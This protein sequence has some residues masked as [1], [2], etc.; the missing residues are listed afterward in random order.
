MLR[1]QRPDLARALAVTHKAIESRNTIPILS[2]VRLVA[3][4]GL[5]TVTATD[6]DIEIQT[7]VP[8]EGEFAACIDAKLLTGIAGKLAADDV[9]IEE[10]DNGQ[11]LLRA[12]KSRYR[13]ATL[14]VSD[15]PAVDPRNFSANF[16]AD[17]AA[18][19]APV[20]FAISDEETRFYLNGIYLHTVAGR[21]T[22]VATD[23]HQ[24]S[25]H[26][27]EATDIF[28]PVIIPR[29]TVSLIP[30][31]KVCVEISEVRIR[32]TA[33][34]TIITSNLINGTYPDYLR[35]VPTRNSK[36]V[37]VDAASLIAAVQR[38]SLLTARGAKLN[39][40]AG[41][42]ALMARG[43]DGEAEDAIECIYDGEPTDVGMN[44]AYLISAL[45]AMPK[46]NVILH[47]EDAG[48]PVLLTPADGG[49]AQKVVLM[50]MRI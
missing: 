11:A 5:L 23:G 36:L 7:R 33:G 24:L 48:S 26:I 46:G 4:G 13:L 22:A 35:V 44:P 28:A 42:I 38:V 50:P 9:T 19:F 14:P 10:T 17:L 41:N 31:G 43:D 1:I 8:A 15:F 12:G 49:D 18:L 25:Q 37:T 27:G 30:A 47:L 6:L 3:D 29:K 20:Q 40:E 34:N 2:M 39:V 21:L 16:E 32:I 45:S